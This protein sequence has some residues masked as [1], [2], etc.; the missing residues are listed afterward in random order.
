MKKIQDHRFEV[1]EERSLIDL[2]LE[3]RQRTPK[4]KSCGTSTLGNVGGVAKVC[5][6]ARK[7]KIQGWRYTY[8]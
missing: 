6:R 2:T 1:G 3:L 5:V 7:D 4:K 8:S